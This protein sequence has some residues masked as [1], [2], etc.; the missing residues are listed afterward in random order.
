LQTDD[1]GSTLIREERLPLSMKSIAVTVLGCLIGFGAAS[2]QA[3]YTIQTEA[4]R[5]INHADGS[6]DFRDYEVFR[7]RT[8]QSLHGFKSRKIKM[9]RF[10]GR[11]DRKAKPTGYFYVTKDQGR[12]WAVDPLGHYYF[13]NAVN[14]VSPGASD[15]NKK[16]LG[17]KFG[18]LEGWI[19]GTHNLLRSLGFNGTGAWT[20]TTFNQQSPLRDKEPLSYT[21]NL[22][23][24]S[25][26]G[27]K[28]GGTYQK[29]GHR[30]Y[31]NNVIF[32][33]DPDFELYCREEAKKLTQYRNDPNL[34]GYFSDNEMPLG[35]KNLDGYL[36]LKDQRDPGYVAA[37]DWLGK[38]G[39]SKAEITDR[40]REAFLELVAQR[41]FSVVNAALK[42][43][44]PNHLYL[45]CRFYGSQKNLQSLFKAAGKYADVISVNYYNVWTPS[46]DELAKWERWS[47]KPA[48]IS[49]WYVKGEDSGLGNTAGAGWIVRTQ[50]DRG[51]F[52]QNFTL[53]LI[54]S[55]NCIGWHWF[56]Y[57]DN[58]PTTVGAEPSNTD[59]N[60]GLVDN[61][62][63]PYGPLV[64]RMKQLNGNMYGLADYFSRQQ[65]PGNGSR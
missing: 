21:V 50:A 55:G 5:G 47:G 19:L 33:F 36:S 10:G 24:M 44:D 49:E 59:A 9:D 60:K 39:I 13:H 56:K 27:R 54:E 20:N 1:A 8:V 4:R 30:G 40:H 6:N 17:E 35:L 64:D 26:Y 15:R 41:Y 23:W 58:D 18:S 31:P 52:Y 45:G 38:Q 11:T 22:D 57:L 34:F 28:R 46:S 3:D 2:R 51:T 53:A 62:Y 12:W 48:L 25:G 65:A 32:V 61:Y 63:T 14:A 29:P 43:A 42:A 7:S 16:A 37:S